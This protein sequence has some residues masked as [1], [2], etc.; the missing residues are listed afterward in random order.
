[1]RQGSG[2]KNLGENVTRFFETISVKCIISN[3]VISRVTSGRVVKVSG[4]RPIRPA[5]TS[6]EP[7]G[8]EVYRMNEVHDRN[9]EIS[10]LFQWCRLYLRNNFI[11]PLYILIYIERKVYQE[12]PIPFNTTRINSVF[13][14]LLTDYFHQ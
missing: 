2:V 3:V 13:V 12:L 6:S 5:V 14:S 10:W 8:F 4:N 9:R 1:M 11:D 7:Y